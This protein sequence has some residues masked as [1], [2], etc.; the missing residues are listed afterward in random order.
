MVALFTVTLFLS[1]F[2]PPD[3]GNGVIVEVVKNESWELIT[4]D[5]NFPVQSTTSQYKNGV[6]HMRTNIYSLPAG[7]CELQKKAIKYG[8]HPYTILVTPGGMVLAKQVYN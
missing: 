7:H 4:C 1:S 2:T 8:S 5:G 6:L 3:N